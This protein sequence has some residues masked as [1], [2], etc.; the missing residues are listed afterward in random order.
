MKKQLVNF[1]VHLKL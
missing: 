1:E